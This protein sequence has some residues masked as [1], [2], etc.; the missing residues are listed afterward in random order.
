MIL[1]HACLPIPALPQTVLWGGLY[2][3]WYAKRYAAALRH[4]EMELQFGWLHRYPFRDPWWWDPW[5][6]TYFPPPYRE[7]VMPTRE[8]VRARLE[9]EHCQ[10][11]CGCLPAYDACFTGCGG[12]IVRET[13]CVKNCPAGE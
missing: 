10:A 3:K 12:Q 1:S 8:G 6:W 11:D 4:Y 5:P 13:V 7:P 9:K 2:H